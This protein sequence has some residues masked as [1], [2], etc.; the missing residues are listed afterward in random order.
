MTPFIEWANGCSG[1]LLAWVSWGLL[2]GT[3]LAVFTWALLRWPLRRAAPVIHG[4][5]WLVV[6]LKFLTPVGP[7]WSWSLASGVHSIADMARIETPK[8]TQPGG[9][10]I[11]LTTDRA[12][13]NESGPV[14][15]TIESPVVSVSVWLAGA[16]VLGVALIGTLRLRT[17]RRFVRQLNALPEAPENVHQIVARVCD[18][19][20]LSR[21]P[22]VRISAEPLSP[23]VCGILRPMLV[24]SCRDIGDAREIEAIAVH[25]LAHIRRGDL[26]VRCLQ[27]FAAALLFFWPVVAWVNRRIDL[28][29]EMACDEWALR[30]STISAGQYARCLLRAAAPARAAPVGLFAA[31]MAANPS[32]V[33]R[34]IE[35]ILMSD[36]SSRRSWLLPVS[37][38]ALGGWSA[39]VLAGPNSAP[40]VA[41]DGDCQQEMVI[42]HV[43]NDDVD[44]TDAAAGAPIFMALP[45]DGADAVEFISEDSADDSTGLK[46]KKVTMSLARGP[47]AEALAKFAAAHPTA[48]ADH[49][50]KVTRAEHDAYI[51]ALAL[52]DPAA[53]LAQFP[54]ADRDND[55]ILSAAEAARLVTMPPIPSIA[56]RFRTKILGA[57][58]ADAGA[59]TGEHREI[60][61]NG[62][63][64]ASA[65]AGDTPAAGVRVMKINRNG[66]EETIV[67]NGAAPTEF[68]V[69]ATPTPVSWI[70][71]NVNGNPTAADVAKMVSLVSDAPLAAFLE[72]NPKADTNGDGKLTAEERSAFLKEKMTAM[73]RRLLEKFPAADLNGDG[74]LSP[75]EIKAHFK[76]MHGA[77]SNGRAM[78]VTHEATSDGDDDVTIEVHAAEKP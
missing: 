63:S 45:F 78:I 7:E 74:E 53:V 55:G 28:V 12:I 60:I 2:G 21:V 44:S 11:L 58:G 32:H 10:A 17:Y 13:A 26:L 38:A 29:R 24:L 14:S 41:D 15:H 35:M 18:R 23:L 65:Q 73:H 71:K 27:W 3:V 8:P 70:T 46:Q 75:D 50:G 42:L 69:E 51:A 43:E 47:G 4:A 37:A 68:N 52:T 40:K 20:G 39:F 59:T 36:K 54:K 9:P 61:L 31:A 5:L 77:A 72:Q 25:E 57:G 6:L 66:K 34:R 48:D 76:S 67:E 22:R 62:E 1:S 56:P 64:G 30:H 33:E 16:Y 49:D 19:L